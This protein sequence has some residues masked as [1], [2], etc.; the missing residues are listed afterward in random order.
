[1]NGYRL[2]RD[3]RS[4]ART[5]IVWPATRVLP[6]ERPLS[7]PR[8]AFCRQNGHRLARDA[9][10]TARTAIV[11]PATRVLPPERPLS[12]PRRAFCRQNGHC[13]A[14]REILG[15]MLLDILSAQGKG[16]T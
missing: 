15:P 5:A 1:L 6:P 8:R 13:L 12:G 11:W 2:A 10:S 9:R 3:A 14:G 16:G 4:A 7:G